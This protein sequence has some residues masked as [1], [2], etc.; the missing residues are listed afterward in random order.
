M[1]IRISENLRSPD[2][3]FK[4]AALS[5][6]MRF[7]GLAL[8]FLGSIWVARALGAEGFGAFTL[9]S[10]WAV[11]VGMML[12]L[13]L[14]ELAV[15]EVPTYLA[16]LQPRRILGF[17]IVGAVTIV[18]TSGV[19][20][21]L[22]A[23]LER[24]GILVLS[25]GWKLVALMAALHGLILSVSHILNGFQRI[26]TSQFLETIVRPMLYLGVLLATVLAGATLTAANVFT[27]SMLAA[28]PILAVM[29]WVAVASYRGK[30][31][32]SG[33]PEYQIAIWFS[34]AIPVFLTAFSNRLQLDLDVLMIGALL[35]NHEVGIYRAAARG[36]LLLSIANMVALQLVGPM[37]SRALANGDS[38][39]A[40]GFLTRA[41]IVSLVAG[42]PICLLLG[43]GAPYYLALFGPE[44]T[45]ASLS[46]RLLLIGQATIIFA[47]ADA[48]L[49]VMLRREK[50]VT[51]VT[52][53]GVILNFLLN[54]TLIGPF[55]IEGAAVASLVSMALV[56]IVLVTVILRQT[57]F[58]PT[59]LRLFGRQKRA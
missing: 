50:L 18:V 19:M 46:L 49:L 27:I 16:K 55:G 54:L 42:L 24:N 39:A 11:F 26:L 41:A 25:P 43:F 23:L 53:I 52:A 9:A 3:F 32:G 20:A 1:R 28:V 4:K 17:V 47:G 56:R 10:T 34:A 21:A 40:Q 35:G 38:A 15:R 59:I 22:F 8:Q 45:Q 51:I 44:F 33:A 36:A 57:G 30:H 6:L 7:G 5:F 58:D 13:G 29:I 2:S 31:K 37:L 14:G 12:S 48:I